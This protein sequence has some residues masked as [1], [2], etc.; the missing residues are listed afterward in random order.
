MD[1]ALSL[2]AYR[3]GAKLCLM[4]LR[5][6]AVMLAAVGCLSC[7]TQNKFLDDQ[8]WSQDAGPEGG[9]WRGTQ[10]L[11]MDGTSDADRF[12]YTLRGVRQD[13]TLAKSAKTTSSC[14]CL[15]IAVGRPR[16]ARFRWAGQRP[17]IAREEEVVAI[18]TEG[19]TCSSKSGERRPSI[20]AVDVDNGDV[21]VVI[22]ELPF[23]RPQALGAIVARPRPGGTLYVRSR[24]RVLYREDRGR[25]LPYGRTGLLKHRCKV[26]TRGAPPRPP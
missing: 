21:T 3:W 7:A 25:S 15:D 20:R 8:D 12:R 1:N 18:R 14:P 17:A 4:K 22:E 24:R 10:S 11:F 6:L 5:L 2:P 23:D 19:S 16:D 9:R 13:L 26:Y